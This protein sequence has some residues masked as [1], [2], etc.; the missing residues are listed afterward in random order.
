MAHINTHLREPWPARLLRAI[1]ERWWLRH[2]LF[3]LVRTVLLTWLVLYVVHVALNLRLALRDMTLLLVPHMLATYALL[4]GVLPA[5]WQGR[6]ARLVGLLAAWFP[7]SVVLHHGFR[8]FVLVPLYVGV[9]TPIPDAHLALAPGPYV[10]LAVTAGVAA[11]LHVYRRWRQKELANGHLR[12]ENYRSELQLLR[13]QIHPHFLFNTLNNLYALTL[14]QSAQAPEVVDR[15]TGLLQFVVEQGHAAL[16]PLPAEV[17]L[18]RNFLALEQL[19]YGPRLTLD[20]RAEGLPA[21]GGIAPLLLLPLVENAFKHGAAEQ[22]G[23]A[24]IAVVLGMADGCFTCLITNTKTD[25]PSAAPPGIGLRN[26]RHRLQLLYPER[27]RFE[28]EA[29]PDTYTVRL[30]LALAEVAAP[31]P[32][33]TGRVA[34]PAAVHSAS[35][36]FPSY[37]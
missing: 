28:T 20:F 2:G 27:H 21:T 16:V 11:C 30:T 17:A 13:A 15:L 35:L 4:Y 26:V 5:L 32:Q 33:R 6:R 9:Q 36:A 34:T 1:D 12:Q 25:A 10:L 31:A 14:R 3:W 7:L 18:L 23:A 22:V 29:R 19:R 37:S 24:R 8:H